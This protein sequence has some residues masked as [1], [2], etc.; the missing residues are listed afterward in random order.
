M[1]THFVSVRRVGVANGRLVPIPNT[2]QGFIESASTRVLG[3]G[4][5][6]RK[7]WNKDGDEIDDVEVLAQMGVV[8]VGTDAE[9]WAIPPTDNVQLQNMVD[10]VVARQG[11][12]P[13]LGP[14]Q[15]APP[16]APAAGILDARAVPLRSATRA[17]NPNG[18]MV[19]TLEDYPKDLYRNV[20][21]Q[22]I[23]ALGAPLLARVEVVKRLT[24]C[25]TSTP[26][27]ISLVDQ[28]W[29]WCTLVQGAPYPPTP[30]REKVWGLLIQELKKSSY[31]RV[32][33]FADTLCYKRFWKGLGTRCRREHMRDA[34]AYAIP[35]SRL[36]VQRG[37][38]FSPLVD[39]RLVAADE[40]LP[41]LTLAEQ[42]I[43]QGEP[44]WLLKGQTDVVVRSEPRPPSTGGRYGVDA[45]A[46]WQGLPLA[47]ATPIGLPFAAATPIGAIGG[48][49]PAFE[50]TGTVL[51]VRN[52]LATGGAS[53]PHS[54]GG[55]GSGLPNDPNAGGQRGN[56]VSVSPFAHPPH[57]TGGLG[58]GL[59]NAPLNGASAPSGARVVHVSLEEVSAAEARSGG[60]GDEVS[61]GAHGDGPEERDPAGTGHPPHHTGGL[62]SGLMNAPLNGASAP[63]GARVVHVSLEEV[64]AAEARSGG[65]G[66]EVSQGAHGDGP[67][68]R[69]PAG[70]GHMPN[71][72]KT[73]LPPLNASMEAAFSGLSPH[74][75]QEAH[76]AVYTNTA[77]TFEVSKTPV[78]GD[79]LVCCNYPYFVA[80]PFAVTTLKE[81]EALRDQ[82]TGDIELADL[83]F[84]YQIGKP[85]AVDS[86]GDLWVYFY[87]EHTIC[88]AGVA[89]KAKMAGIGLN[90][91]LKYQ[92]PETGSSALSAGEADFL[93]D[94]EEFATTGD[95]NQAFIAKHLPGA[96]KPPPHPKPK[97]PRAKKTKKRSAPGDAENSTT[98]PALTE[99][100]VAQ[101][102]A[103][104][105]Y[106]DATKKHMKGFSK[107][108]Q[109]HMDGVRDA[110][111]KLHPKVERTDRC[112]PFRVSCGQ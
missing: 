55:L 14:P 81:Q 86:N 90:V 32:I 3:A 8:Y 109:W 56:G 84:T 4:Q 24:S 63:S 82:S 107:K 35:P 70:T 25:N 67:E 73:T 77:A 1:T 45:D 58:S 6:A 19:K 85:L 33:Q 64:S 76:N 95:Y 80:V 108:W 42:G 43:K 21:P 91:V 15:M 59:M 49:L 16:A 88:T 57:H 50:P 53:L 2:W 110:L 96:P 38:Y 11:D 5:V 7:V 23:E 9:D 36:T 99:T 103:W 94:A 22:R 79:Q 28:V 66:D 106:D 87:K 83:R 10:Q 104:Q 48:G 60:E 89:P 37:P 52:P 18:N 51:P 92:A 78:S 20:D 68:E 47:A 72:D 69:D 39:A 46:P 30:L 41:V 100:E 44:G 12:S 54:T 71:T 27:W 93:N 29:L 34:T 98:F 40:S 74:R 97:K 17:H 75:C 112:I 13:A 62:G 111:F 102:R 65:E 31:S 61:Q 26:E 105:E 101:A